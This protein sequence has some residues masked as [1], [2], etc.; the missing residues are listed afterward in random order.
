MVS[1]HYEYSLIAKT[2]FILNSNFGLGLNENGDSETGEVPIYGIH[3]GLL[4]LIGT[5]HI[6]FELGLNPTTYF[7]RATTFVNLN[8]WTGIRLS[9]QKMDGF[10][11]SFGYTP[12]LYTTY[13]NPTNQFFNATIGAK[14]GIN[15]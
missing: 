15:F 10:F 14:F 9:P 7:H 1:F 8:G 12:R 2:H 13:S 6:S 11:M 5:K 4:C 3:T